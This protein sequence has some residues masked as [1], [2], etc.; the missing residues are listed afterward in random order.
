MRKRLRALWTY[1]KAEHTH[2]RRLAVA[3]FIGVM[4]GC[5]PIYGLHT[6]LCLLIAHVFK[7][8]KVAIVSASYISNPLMAPPLVAAGIVV[9]EWVRFGTLRA[10]DLHEATHFIEGLSMFAGRVPDL[11]LSCLIGDTLIALVLAPTLALV[12]YRVASRAQASERQVAG[13]VAAG[14]GDA[15]GRGEVGVEHVAGE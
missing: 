11:W 2:P 3:V 1:L 6:I 7:L 9:G 8:N 10:L 4:I 15:A 14:P 12:A 13:E 5:E